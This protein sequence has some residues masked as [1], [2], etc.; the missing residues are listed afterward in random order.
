[1]RA[2]AER[3]IVSRTAVMISWDRYF[4]RTVAIGLDFKAARDD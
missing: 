2:A 4:D 3:V 1:L